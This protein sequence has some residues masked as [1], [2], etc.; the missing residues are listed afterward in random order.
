MTL[1]ILI[2]FIDGIADLDDIYDSVSVRALPN[3]LTIMTLR[4]LPT[5]VDEGMG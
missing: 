5:W 4:A 2:I 3:T 1:L